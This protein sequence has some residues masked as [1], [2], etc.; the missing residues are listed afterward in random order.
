MLNQL[1]EGETATDSFTYTVTDDHGGQS[2]ATALVTVI[3]ANDAPV[4]RDDVLG[5]MS[6]TFD[7][8]VDFSNYHGFQLQG[9][10]LQNYWGADFSTAAFTYFTSNNG[11][12]VLQRAGGGE[13]SIGGASLTGLFRGQINGGPE[14]LIGYLNGVE[15]ARE[16]FQIPGADRGA[17][18]THNFPITL[19]DAAWQH[20]DKVVFSDDGAQPSGGDY[21]WIDNIQLGIQGLT[22]DLPVLDINVMQN[23]TDADHGAVLS[24]VQFD[25]Q[26]AQGVTIS[27]NGDGTLHYDPTQSAAFLALHPGEAL[28]DTFTYQLQDEHGALSNVATVSVTLHGKNDAPVA[29]ADVASTTENAAVTIDVLATTPMSMPAPC[30]RCKLH[31]SRPARS[32]S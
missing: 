17:G 30:S 26:S 4:A 31:R 2:T 1:A 11:P 9:F 22:A 23:D 18:A 6:L 12:G 3:G 21:T 32:R 10:N 20:V 13:F 14:T 19:Q 8:D 15:V 28:T 25:A 7:D 27:L 16:T 24:V 5:P 29:N